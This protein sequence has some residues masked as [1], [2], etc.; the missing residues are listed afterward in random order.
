MPLPSNATLSVQG[1]S[2]P[3]DTVHSKPKQ[4]MIV[5]LSDETL[6]AID[7]FNPQKPHME[8]DFGKMPGLYIGDHFFPLRPVKEE[9]PHDLYVRAPTA[10]KPMAPLK[11]HANV[12]G[13]FTIERDLDEADI[14]GKLRESAREAEKQRSERKTIM[15]EQPP[16][17]PATNKKR[18]AP[19]AANPIVKKPTQSDR[20]RNAS[21]S[22]TPARVGSP[23]TSAPAPTSDQPDPARDRMLRF[24]V[25]NEIAT[26][27]VTADEVVRAIG[28]GSCDAAMRRRLTELLEQIAEPAPASKGDNSPRKWML[29][30]TSWLET[31]PWQWPRFSYQDRVQ[32]ARKARM[33]LQSLKIPKSS[34]LWATFQTQAD[35][36]AAPAVPPATQ[37]TR[38][39]ASGSGAVK[40]EAKRGISS[41]E[42]KEK[43]AATAKSKV[44]SA[45][46]KGEV[47]MKDESLKASR[48]A[49]ARSKDAE[50]PRVADVKLKQEA[51]PLPAR[52]LP[53]SGFKA[54]ASGSQDSRSDATDSPRP[55]AARPVKRDQLPPSLPAKPVSVLVDE[56][57][58]RSSSASRMR[59]PN[60]A[61]SRPVERQEKARERDGERDRER[62]GERGRDADYNRESAKAARREA[63]EDEKRA[64]RREQE[65]GRDADRDRRRESEH[66]G[67]RDR[68]VERGE[69]MRPAA[70]D[71]RN[72]SPAAGV[73]RKKPIP[74]TDEH[75][76]PSPSTAGDAP[77]RRKTDTGVLPV[78]SA[79]PV[80]DLSLPKKPVL[81]PDDR[82]PLPRQRIK[83]EHSPL[84][85]SRQSLPNSN[86]PP[87]GSPLAADGR[88]RQ[89]MAAARS[90]RRSPIYTSSEDEGQISS[91]NPP[92]G[93]H[94]RARPPAPDHDAIRARYDRCYDVY[95]EAFKRVR[96]QQQK[97]RRALARLDSGMATDSDGESELMDGD[98]IQKLTAH[99]NASVAELEAIRRNFNGSGGSGTPSD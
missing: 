68:V 41:K 96:R 72:D 99:Y 66:G 35:P 34:E 48:T 37:S 83:R 79:K 16:V 90:R 82:S 46:K 70:Q 65:R 9:S 71:R 30:Q 63:R 25:T 61:S 22:S 7:A 94:R 12:I 75:D 28:G 32:C 87:P 49:S 31:R 3:G 78:P 86:R 27:A 56:P 95:F 42:V 54:S 5:R 19:A 15:L 44:D 88:A 43:K 38:A 60:D 80:R 2:R 98:E 69:R 45:K 57:K 76:R 59:K 24:L 36:N 14:G 8:F 1:H 47:T 89:S 11:L 51:K 52:R 91:R 53:G 74:D 93:A 33:A 23:Q 18:K 58:A 62:G 77:K 73:K 29:K 39:V 92:S 17:L 85:P 20:L 4:A 84:P 55:P 10:A 67:D 6:D 13:K 21:A 40:T 64:E 81:T 50:P 97:A 26:N